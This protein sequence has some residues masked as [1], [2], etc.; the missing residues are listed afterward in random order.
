MRTKRRCRM[1]GGRSTGP[2]R[3]AGL[4]RVRAAR[5]QHGRYSAVERAVERWRRQYVTNGYRSA[6]AMPDERMRAYF[7]RVAGE[8]IPDALLAEQRQA[9]CNE[10]AS[11]E[12][13]RLR[14][15]LGRQPTSK[16][17]RGR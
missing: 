16:H 8:P 9:A 2:R 5:T 17:L 3:A 11:R 10:V 12:A 4:A 15:L 1:H 14:R 6:R 7:L 13:E